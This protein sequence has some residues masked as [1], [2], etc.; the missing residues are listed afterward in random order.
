MASHG[1]LTRATNS[2][3]RA[4]TPVPTVKPANLMLFEPV[5]NLYSSPLSECHTKLIDFGFARELDVPTG[6]VAGATTPLPTSPVRSLISTI[7]LSPSLSP[8]KRRLRGVSHGS[9]AADPP[10]SVFGDRSSS[11]AEESPG[12][13]RPR[14]YNGDGD[15]TFS[16][17]THRGWKSTDLFPRSPGAH[18]RPHFTH[19][20]GAQES[21]QQKARPDGKQNTAAMS[22]ATETSPLSS[23]NESFPRVLTRPPSA[24][25]PPPVVTE[26]SGEDDSDATGLRA[27]GVD[28][29]VPRTQSITPCGTRHYAEPMLQGGASD[30]SGK[31]DLCLDQALQLDTYSLGRLLRYLL[32]GVPPDQTIM[33]ALSAQG[34][35]CSCLLALCGI[36]P[37]HRRRIVELSEVSTLARELLASLSKPMDERASVFEAHSHRWLSDQS[38]HGRAGA[39]KAMDE[40]Q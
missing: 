6:P 15:I 40:G 3:V 30:I 1:C 23:D 24:G 37:P 25:P 27:A 13:R 35:D 31:L 29:R 14:P 12:L 38:V 21:P 28:V 20:H 10:A 22:P 18:E 34:M 26:P 16:A 7:R 5:P 17:N 39:W 36:P 11:T 33:D 32:T 4:S 2:T 19:T 8:S 9:A